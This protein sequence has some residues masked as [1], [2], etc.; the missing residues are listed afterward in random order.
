MCEA[1]KFQID[2]SG[3]TGAEIL[4]SVAAT[5]GWCRYVAVLGRK[6]VRQMGISMCT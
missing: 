4:A 2:V 5:Q 3:A 1:E 6:I